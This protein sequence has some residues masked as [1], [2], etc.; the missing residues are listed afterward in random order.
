MAADIRIGISGWRYAGW[1]GSFYPDDLVR[2]RELEYASRHLNAIEINGSFYSLQRAASWRSWRDE[3][4]EG[5]QFA[6]KG[7]RYITHLKRLKDHEALANFFGSGLLELG[8]KLGPILWQLPPNFR[9]DGERLEGFLKALPRTHEAAAELGARHD[10]RVTDPAYDVRA[11]GR[12]LRHAF[13]FRHRSFFCAEAMDQLRE[14]DVALVVAETAGT[15]PFAEDVTADFV[16][17]RMHGSKSMYQG[18]YSDEALDWWAERIGHWTRGAEPTDATRAGKASKKLR[19]RDV[20]VFFDNDV[21]ARAP[22]DAMRLME[23]L[24]VEAEERWQGD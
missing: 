7:S 16:Y 15:F 24:G 20:H 8:D 13:E 18:S 21:K 11:T 3:V 4:P 2:R 19:S 12:V 5:F 14:H 10:Q 23:R 6:V 9:Y 1:R 17:V 22:F